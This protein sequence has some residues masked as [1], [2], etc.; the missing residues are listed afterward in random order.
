MNR[1]SS[2]VYFLVFLLSVAGA[3]SC[4]G[5]HGSEETVESLPVKVGA[6]V[7]LEEHLDTLRRHKVGL[8]MNPTARV[9]GVHMLDTLL[10]E[11]V[12]VKALYAPE[13]GF[14]GRAAAGERIKD[15]RDEESGL[16]V[17]S[18]YGETRKPTPKMLE[19]VD[20]LLFDIQ[21]VGA[22][23]YTYHVT[24]GRVMEAA[25]KQR[26]P[27]WILDRPNPA[28][29]EYVSGWLLRERYRSFVGEYPMPIVHGMTMGELGRMMIG[30]KWISNSDQADLRI[31]KMEGWT[32]DML[33]P[34]TGLSWYPPSPNLPR[35]EN[36]YVYLGTAFF[37]GT[38]LSEGRGTEDPFL[39]VG[40]PGTQVP[41]TVLK[42][43]ERRYSVL[44]EKISFTPRSI[45]GKAVDPKYEGENI[46][47]VRI[48]IEG[49]PSA[50][51][52]LEFGINLLREM[53]HYTPRVEYKEHLYRLAGTEKIRDYLKGESE[54]SLKTRWEEEVGSFK[55]RRQPYLLYPSSEK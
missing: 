47:G 19:G 55:E 36:A 23:F 28:G 2:V 50:L 6:E 52:P 15:G 33:W 48:S 27:V 7:L 45:K 29:G 17:Y 1:S 14:R 20:L 18:L 4:S 53:I 8:V 30:E 51:K 16:P 11:N 26:I 10:A 40:A 22:R 43:L 49:G 5:Q 42:Q 39:M 37:E 25:A 32:R 44:L 24:L 54:E 13:H 3:W 35:F 31:I 46:Q 12:P 41:D 38:T 21:D 9:N 34:E